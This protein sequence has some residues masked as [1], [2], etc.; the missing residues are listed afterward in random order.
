MASFPRAAWLW[1]WLRPSRA[2]RRSCW[3]PV[4]GLAAGAAFD[5]RRGVRLGQLPKADTEQADLERERGE[6]ATSPEASGTSW[7]GSTTPR[8]LSRELAIQVADQL[9]AHDALR[10]HARDE[11]GIHETTRARPIQ[12]AVASAASFTAGRRHR[13]SWRR[14]CLPDSDTGRR[15]SDPGAPPRARGRCGSPWRR[16]AHPRGP[17][18]CV[19]GCGGHGVYCRRRT[20]LWRNRLTRLRLRRRGVVPTK[21]KCSGRGNNDRGSNRGRRF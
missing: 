11:L 10:A 12:A 6:L 21:E 20:A 4:A 16:P 7:R 8:G 2:A 1:V 13:R 17:A 9:M 14:C 19:L 15:G 18:R 5:G 3:L